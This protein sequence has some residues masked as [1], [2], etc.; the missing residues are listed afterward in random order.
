MTDS[1][2]QLELLYQEA[3]PLF[4]QSQSEEELYQNKVNY[5]GKKGKITDILKTL[6]QLSADLKPK[7]GAKANQVRAE[8]EKSYEARLFHLK[9]AAVQKALE[10]D[11]IDVTLPALQSWK[12][13][14]HPLSQVLTEMKDLFKRM[15]FDI[16]EG[17]EIENDH[18]N[19]EALNVPANHPARDMQDTFYVEDL[20]DQKGDALLLRTHTSPVQIRVMLENKPPIQMVAP[21]PVYRCDSDVSHTPMF[22]QIEGLL[23]DKGVNLSH[24]K[25]VLE[26]FLKAI[27]E[28]DLPVRFRPSYFPF[29]EPSAEVD[30]GCVF[31]SSKGCRIC[32]GTGWIEIM[33]CGMVH[34]AVFEGVGI[35]T[36]EYSGFA[37]GIGIERVAMLKYGINDLRLFFENDPRFLSQF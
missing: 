36:H 6:G 8:L 10:S 32:K 14:I 12:G 26:T 11:K 23:V 13:S 15:G 35:D 18:H 30:I 2:Q 31:C 20:K 4:D 5:L 37:F 1:L 9:A 21:G 24:L 7:V 25:A 27:F 16:F 33:G 19:F 28:K 17:P 29:T 22:H 34:P 3:L